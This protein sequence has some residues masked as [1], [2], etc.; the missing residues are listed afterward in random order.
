[1]KRE[2]HKRKEHSETGRDSKRNMRRKRGV[3]GLQHVCPP[4]ILPCLQLKQLLISPAA[5]LVLTQ[6]KTH[7]HCIRTNLLIHQ[8]RH[9]HAHS[10]STISL[11]SQI[12][13]PADNSNNSIN[14]D[15]NN[16][17]SDGQ[18]RPSLNLRQH[19]LPSLPLLK[20]NFLFYFIKDQ[21]PELQESCQDMPGRW[22]IDQPILS[23]EIN[24]HPS[25][26]IG[27]L[28]SS[29][30]LQQHAWRPHIPTWP[31]LS[32]NSERRSTPVINLHDLV[33][34]NVL[35]SGHAVAYLYCLSYRPE[36]NFLPVQ[37]I[38]NVACAVRNITPFPSQ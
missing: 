24:C 21:F 31:H 4:A 28:V 27:D 15:P 2:R 26:S 25:S 34:F 30:C 36:N 20:K 9:T 17:N 22:L 35:L 7:I 5:S 29:I 1:M 14:P 3:E 19:I 12:T 16:N 10:F 23:Q 18:P 13:S 6:R 11:L 38:D 8:Q 33:D 37:G 32:H